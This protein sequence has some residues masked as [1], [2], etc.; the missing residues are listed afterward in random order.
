MKLYEL[1]K[2]DKFVMDPGSVELTFH[3]MDGMFGKATDKDGH[4]FMI[5]ATEKIIKIN[6]SKCHIKS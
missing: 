3:G 2:D 4:F 6:D 1:S 5:G